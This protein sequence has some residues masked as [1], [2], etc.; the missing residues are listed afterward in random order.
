MSMAIMENIFS[1]FVLPDNFDDVS[2]EKA[3]FRKCLKENCSSELYLQLSFKNFANLCFIP[4][5]L[6]KV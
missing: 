1:V 4:K 6:S 3:I 2:L 5:L